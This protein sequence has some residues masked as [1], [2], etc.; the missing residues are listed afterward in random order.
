MVTTSGRIV[1]SANAAWNI[2]NFR[3]GLIRGLRT[4][5]FEIVVVAGGELKNL[6]CLFV[7]VEIDKKGSNPLRDL[8][9]LAAY[10]RILR[11]QKPVAYLGFT[12]KPNI[13]GSMAAHTL[14]IPVFNNVS[15]LG[16][17]FI[18]RSWL[19]APVKLLYR[20]AF[21]KSHTVF[22]QNEDD[23]R[24]FTDGRLVDPKRTVLLPGSGVDLERF[25]MTAALGTPPPGG[26]NF[27][28]VARLLWDKG[29]GEYVDAAR[30]F[31][32]KHPHAHFSILGFLDAENR[33]AISRQ[34][35]DKWV[36]EGI[37]DYLGE[38]DDVRPF[39]AKAD[40]VVLPS[41]REGT[42]RSL[43]EAAAMGKPLI[44]TDVPGCR[45][46]VDDGVNGFL[47]RVQ[48][49]DDLAAKMSDFAALSPA[50]VKAMGQAGR[51]KAERQFDERIV[52]ARIISAIQ[53]IQ[54]R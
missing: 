32:A 47:C 50:A 48:D 18:R 51:A 54:A 31:K 52:V 21:R 26:L 37:I 20:L 42:P 22:F 38:S 36:A 4:S 39:L 40:C 44:T 16:T 35:V 19:T 23:R 8:R 17:V 6:D 15:G 41:Y 13:Y 46:V 27:L 53:S 7:P 33:T 24:L 1:V 30:L 9:L 25:Q 45:E 3:S 2:V 14:G 43:L 12:I 11:A 5:G 34:T 10:R 28:L 29:V 49:P